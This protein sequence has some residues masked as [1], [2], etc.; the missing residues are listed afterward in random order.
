MEK[1]TPHD[2]SK[3]CGPQLQQ[4]V[5]THTPLE[6][7]DALAKLDL[8]DQLATQLVNTIN[9][10]RQRL[11]GLYIGRF[12]P[13]HNGH[14][15]IVQAMLEECE[16]LV[17][18]IG[19]P[20]KSHSERNPFTAEERIEMI[21]ESLREAGVPLEKVQIVTI[22]DIGRPALWAKHVESIT[23]RFGRVYSGSAY[24]A[25]L[26]KEEGGYDVK[27]LSLLKEGD[28]PISATRIRESMV[29][30]PAYT[31]TLKGTAPWQQMIPPAV[32]RIIE[33]IGGE[34]RLRAV[35]DN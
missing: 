3:I 2:V 29:D 27:Q 35:L 13:F 14:M 7:G 4:L 12:Q 5:D 19:S 26:F 10:A 25:R 21:R 9:K 23:P 11:T 1:I 22:P 8:L 18:G 28:E 33:K 24:V 20:Y 31:Y 30:N 32:A 16:E 17:I 34:E 15:S 6:S